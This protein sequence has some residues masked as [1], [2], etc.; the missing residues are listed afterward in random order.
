LL[1]HFNPILG[2][3]IRAAWEEYEAGVTPE[4]RWVREMDKLDCLIKA[5]DYELQTYGEKDLEE[6]QSLTPKITSEE[7]KAWL[8]LLQEERKAHLSRLKQRV[9][10]IF[11]IGISY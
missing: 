1:K 10:A 4:A 3:K 8:R 9:P 11:V 2:E 6:F 7:G 5:F